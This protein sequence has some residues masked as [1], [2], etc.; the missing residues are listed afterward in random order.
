L[1]QFRLTQQQLTMPKRLGE[2]IKSLQSK[3]LNNQ[4]LRGFSRSTAA[5]L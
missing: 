4:H 1:R 2:R 3:H 5:E